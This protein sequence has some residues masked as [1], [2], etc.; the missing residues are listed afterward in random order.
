M[1]KENR[2]AAPITRDGWTLVSRRRR[3][4]GVSVCCVVLCAWAA[5]H[6]L[7]SRAEDATESA[8]AAA[9]KVK[10]PPLPELGKGWKRLEVD[11]K[12][13]VWVHAKKK[14]VA[15]D[16]VVCLNRGYLEM[17]ACIVNTKEHESVVAVQSKAYVLHAALLAVGAKSGSPATW[18]PKY[19]PA[20]G[21]KVHVEV[22]YLKDGKLKRTKA[23]EW[24][25]DL[26]TRKA[27]TH[28]WVFG[29]SSIWRD[30]E[31]KKSYYRA[32]SGDLICVSNFP[33]AMLDLPIKSSQ[34]DDELAFEAFTENIPKRGT[35]VR[36]YLIPQLPKQEEPKQDKPKP[37]E[38][39]GK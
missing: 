31:T 19:T 11:K 23:Q 28:D 33:T 37:G 20:R 34:A 39:K 30:P 29:G 32:E 2:L 5:L 36:V 7:P 17:F 14:Q 9:E 12:A 35:P 1:D 10:R 22:E 18:R 24:I 25:R 16:G 21:T 27:M 6:A 13:R 3:A 8:V 4:F 15:V 26:K 38:N